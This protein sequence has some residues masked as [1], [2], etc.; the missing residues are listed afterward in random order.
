M[1]VLAWACV[2]WVTPFLLLKLNLDEEGLLLALLSMLFLFVGLALLLGL[3]WVVGAFL[4]GFAL[5][6]FPTQGVVRGQLSSLS[7]FFLAVFF[8]SL[9]AI[10][11][12]PAPRELVLVA[13][14]VCMV[15]VIT[16]MLVT[17]IARRLG[18]T[19]RSSI[20]SGLLLAQCSEFSLILALVGKEQGHLDDRM[21]GVIA[22]VTVITMIIT[23]FLATDRVTWRIMRWQLPWRPRQ[24]PDRAFA[25][26]VLMLGCGTNGLKLLDRLL[27]LNLTVVVVDDDPA[28]VRQLQSRGVEAVRGDGADEAL[29]RSVKAAKARTI[30]SNMRRLEDNLRM[31]RQA[32]GVQVLVR[33]FAPE[34]ADLIRAAGGTPIVDADAAAEGFFNWFDHRSASEQASR[35]E[36]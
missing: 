22:L 25:D 36:G 9:G 27:T 13:I 2:Q 34:S 20:E 28:V 26:H 21:L 17:I 10:L 18:M 32:S 8:V 31:L 4:A 15:I 24:L 23:P 5:S 7:D 6:G 35:T 12:L 19:A 30:I 3:P 29:L 33:V 11:T 14:L 16:P 1:V